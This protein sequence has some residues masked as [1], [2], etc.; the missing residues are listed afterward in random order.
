MR[1]KRAAICGIVIVS[2]LSVQSPA[3]A[4]AKFYTA[5]KGSTKITQNAPQVK[6]TPPEAI[7][8]TSTGT[9]GSGKKILWGTLGAVALIG[10]IAAVMSGGSGSSSRSVN[11]EPEP[12]PD[13]E[14]G[15][16]QVSW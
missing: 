8:T 12:E 9:K 6:T 16:V 10:L 5:A 2:F 11:P 15:S 13:G 3:L 1:L 14:T 7:P 4:R